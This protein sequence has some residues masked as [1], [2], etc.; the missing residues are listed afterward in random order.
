MFNK[1]SFANRN[2]IVTRKDIRT[3]PGGGVRISC[4]SDGMPARLA[5]ATL[6]AARF[7]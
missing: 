7:A 6:S 5:H 4:D 2:D 1:P 3:A